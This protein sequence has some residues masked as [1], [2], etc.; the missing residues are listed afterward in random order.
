[1]CFCQYENIY[2]PPFTFTITICF[3]FALISESSRPMLLRGAQAC[4]LTSSQ[5]RYILSGDPEGMEWSQ[6]VGVELWKS[7]T[8][9]NFIFYCVSF[10]NLYQHLG[11]HCSLL[12]LTWKLPLFDTLLL[13]LCLGTQQTGT[14][15]H[16]MLTSPAALASAGWEISVENGKPLGTSS[17]FHMISGTRKRSISSVS[18][19]SP[20]MF[21]ATSTSVLFRWNNWDFQGRPTIWIGYYFNVVQSISMLY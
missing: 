15:R 9:W 7:E 17:S 19:G 4:G 3:M 18:T 6:G 8:C 2:T 21:W 16:C 20:N 5:R 14:L 1:M 10:W 11:F 12:E 13:G